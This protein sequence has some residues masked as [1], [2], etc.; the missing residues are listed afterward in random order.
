MK[1][2][3]DLGRGSNPTN[4]MRLSGMIRDACARRGS[5]KVI[6]FCDEN[7]CEWLRDSHDRLDQLQI[8][9]FGDWQTQ[10]R[11]W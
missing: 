3:R 11:P 7:E 1:F 2:V 10:C 5:A 6:L 8:R 9:L 4:R